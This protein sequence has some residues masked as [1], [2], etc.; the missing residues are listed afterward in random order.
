MTPA[1]RVAS[2]SEILDMILEGTAAEKALTTW[3]RGS[4]FAGSKDRAAVRD[5]V[6]QALRCMRSYAALGGAEVPT[7]RSLMLGALRANGTDL[8]SIFSGEGHAPQPLSEDELAGGRAAVAGAEAADIPDWLWPEFEAALGAEAGA[9]AALM[10][11]RADV[12]LR[13]NT[14]MATV[15]EAQ[16]AL[17]EEGVVTEPHPLSPTALRVVEGGRRVRL[18]HAFDDGFVELQDAASQAVVDWL[19]L[20]GT[21]R[22]LDYCAGGGG[23]SLAMTAQTDARIVAS[24]IA[25]ERMKDLP[26]RST[27]AGAAIAI[28]TPEELAAEPAFDLVLCDAPCSGSGAWR[29]APEGKWR[30]TEERLQELGEAQLEVLKAARGH[31]ADAG[32][33][34][35]VTCSILRRENEEM[36]ARFEA[37]CPEWVCTS[38]QRWHPSMGGDGFFGALFARKKV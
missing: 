36:V 7:G 28:R 19:P 3:A 24:D 6:F 38:S 31:V 20:E 33:L 23:K 18:T 15:A 8:A 16:A 5:H 4:R 1:A 14:V 10:R 21:A 25:P 37:E 29:R 12:F 9:E 27:R 26:A 11:E 30:L 35:Y 13:V 34:A 22:V 17:A 2:A 32:T